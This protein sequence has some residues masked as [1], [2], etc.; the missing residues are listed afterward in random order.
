MINKNNLIG[1]QACDILIL[2]LEPLVTSLKK[3]ERF[4]QELRLFFL[5]QE[6]KLIIKVK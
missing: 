2:V 1:W 3:M 4:K 5:L 6:E